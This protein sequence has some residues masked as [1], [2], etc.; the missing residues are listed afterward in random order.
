MNK[1]SEFFLH[2]QGNLFLLI[3]AVTLVGSTIHFG[4]WA[5]KSLKRHPLEK[6]ITIFCF[7]F[8]LLLFVLVMN[9]IIT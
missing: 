6:I 8:S 3:I 7:L 5:F 4:Y 2:A 1:L 9:E